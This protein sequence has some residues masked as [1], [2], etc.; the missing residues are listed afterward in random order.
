MAHVLQKFE[1]AKREEGLKILRKQTVATL[2]LGEVM[3]Q[4]GYV[5]A[6]ILA[7]DVEGGELSVLQTIDWETACIKMISAE[8]GPGPQCDAISY[9][10]RPHGYFM[11]HRYMFDNIWVLRLSKSHRCA[12]Q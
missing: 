8:C 7:L 4:Y 6:D 2:P 11:A 5:S 1:R 3:K 9:L 10:L 12:G